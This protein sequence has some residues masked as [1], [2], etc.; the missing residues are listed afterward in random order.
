MLRQ[1]TI[2]DSIHSDSIHSVL[3]EQQVLCTHSFSENQP[4]HPLKELLKE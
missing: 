4:E 2:T 3:A 1:A